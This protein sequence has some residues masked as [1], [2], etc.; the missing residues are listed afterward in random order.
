MFTEMQRVYEL[1]G[2]R[3]QR[4]STETLNLPLLNDLDV[5]G[6]TMGSVTAEQTTLYGNRNNVPSGDLTVYFVRSTNPAYNGC[7]A[8]P[9]NRP[10][11]VVASVASR[12]TLAH[13]CGHVLG[14]RHVDDPPPPNPSAPPALLDRL[15]T[16]R[17]TGSITN[18]PPDLTA[19][20]NLSLRATRLTHNI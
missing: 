20:E 10:G 17:G 14:L 19:Q 4:V 2:I 12:W 8:H 13:E 11:A 1:L 6:C 7:A 16:G 3:V 5:G 9:A 18:P 15:M